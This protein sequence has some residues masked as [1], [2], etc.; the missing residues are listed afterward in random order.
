MKIMATTP[1]NQSQPKFG[2]AKVNVLPGSEGVYNELIRT[3]EDLARAIKDAS[4]NVMISI[5]K[6]SLGKKSYFAAIKPPTSEKSKLVAVFSSG[7]KDQ[8]YQDTGNYIAQAV[9]ENSSA[10]TIAVA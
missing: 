2:A 7:I 9:R 6:T 8:G 3:S 5:G 10:R 1:V 4:E